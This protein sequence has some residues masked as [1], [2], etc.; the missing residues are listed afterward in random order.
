MLT[1][2]EKF[3]IAEHYANTYAKTLEI[4]DR[5]ESF[6]KVLSGEN[7]VFFDSMMVQCDKLALALLSPE[8]YEWLVWW[9][10]DTEFGEKSYSFTVDDVKYNPQELTF[11]QFLEIVWK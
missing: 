10:C 2:E 6:L 3:I 9:V 1:F 7:S 11:G 8:E 5:L 4:Q